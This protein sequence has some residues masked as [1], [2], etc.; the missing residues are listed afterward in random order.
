MTINATTDT[1]KDEVAQGA[2][3]VDF[4]A[5]WCGPCKQ[6]APTLDEVAA[7]GFKVVKVDVDSYPDLA[8]AYGVMGVPALF[9]LKDGEVKERGAGVQTKEKIVETLKGLE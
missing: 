6:L 9:Y 2:V 3:L 1:F 8:G 7:E 4:W 5:P